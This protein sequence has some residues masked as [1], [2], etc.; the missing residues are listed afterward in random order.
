MR[1]KPFV[2]GGFAEQNAV[3]SEPSLV[4]GGDHFGD[5]VGVRIFA[6]GGVPHFG[7]GRGGIAHG[8]D[9]AAQLVAEQSLQQAADVDF[10]PGGEHFDRVE[11]DA[12]GQ[13]AI[14][15]FFDDGGA[16]VFDAL[17]FRADP[18]GVIE[19]RE[20]RFGVIRLFELEAASHLDGRSEEI[21]EILD[22]VGIAPADR[23]SGQ[24][25]AE[26]RAVEARFVG[27]IEL[28]MACCAR[29]SSG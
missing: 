14:V 9:G 6:G 13:T 23:V 19:F 16:F 24:R 2:P 10:A 12:H 27:E 11:V 28:R 18:A 25:L 29:C 4:G 20:E 5:D 17:E 3:G 26:D 21:E 1:E 7:G 22:F 15:G 8:R